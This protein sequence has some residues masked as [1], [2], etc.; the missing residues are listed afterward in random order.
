M[1]IR[2]RSYFADGGGRDGWISSA[3]DPPTL[4]HQDD[5]L[6]HNRLHQSTTLLSSYHHPTQTYQTWQRPNRNSHI[7]QQ[8]HNHQVATYARRYTVSAPLFEGRHDPVDDDVHATLMAN[9]RSNSSTR[10][11]QQSNGVSGGID[12]HAWRH[13]PMDMRTSRQE[14]VA[15]VPPLA[16]PPA[17]TPRPSSSTTSIDNKTPSSQTKTIRPSTASARVTPLPSSNITQLARHP[18]GGGG[19]SG[20]GRGRNTTGSATFDR[21]IERQQKRRQ[22]EHQ[23]EHYEAPPSRSSGDLNLF[24]TPQP[25]KMQPGLKHK[26]QKQFLAKY[27]ADV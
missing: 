7:H 15:Y 1:A 26:G 11:L 10:T 25:V 2:F 19:V 9:N 14:L 8:R 21:A 12:P 20:R 3:K 4:R 17:A 16:P 24:N 23:R 5:Q 18:R 13:L 27:V 22:Q 6:N